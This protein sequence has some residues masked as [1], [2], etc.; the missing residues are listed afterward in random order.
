[1]P[2]TVAAVLNR[3]DGAVGRPAPAAAPEA[4]PAD[5][6]ADPVPPGPQLAVHR[7]SPRSLVALG[8]SAAVHLLFLA[9]L[10]LARQTPPPP[11]EKPAEVIVVEL[12]ALGTP[13]APEEAPPPPP[14][15]EEKAPPPPVAEAAPPP[16]APMPE[17]E[18]PKLPETPPA[19][20]PEP[21][22]P[23]QVK[24][25]PRPLRKPEPEPPV[26]ETPPP[27]EPP[28]PEPQ[29]APLPTAAQ[30]APEQAP[31]TETPRKGIETGVAGATSQAEMNRYVTTLFTMIDAKKVYPPQSLQRREQG[32]VV[33]RLKIA[34]DGKLIDVASP[35]EDP[36]RLVD[37]SLE[38]V[39]RAAP[40]PPL[41]VSLKQ[42][43]AAFE[44]PVVYKVQ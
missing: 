8:F 10:I 9:L 21:V 2:A 17:I 33:V 34:A 16:P 22:V 31:A 5:P 29:P 7:R 12:A 11:V 37:A 44:V 15:P 13:E 14:A 41:P 26:A 24:A 36:R 42:D 32:T 35:T 38:A 19:K 4:A 39:R 18:T 6:P 43:A 40:F 27:A 28:L 1:M 23:P 20:E 3:R 25:V 30:P